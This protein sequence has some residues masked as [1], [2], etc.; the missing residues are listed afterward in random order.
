VDAAKGMIA[1]AKENAVLSGLGSSPIRF[2]VDDCMKFVQREARRGKKYDA[3]IMDPPSYGRG[4][5]GELWK[6]EDELYHL[7]EACMEVLSDEPLFFLINSYT[8]GFSPQ[9]PANLL[10]YFFRDRKGRAASGE[11]G[12]PIGN[13]SLIL[14]CGTYARWWME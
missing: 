5:N 13:T 7:V 11:L 14:P 12:L 10:A 8:T 9:V 6:L 1:W 2:I 3:I 4:P